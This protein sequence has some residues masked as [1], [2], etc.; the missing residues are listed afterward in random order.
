MAVDVAI[1][2]KILQTWKTHEVPEVWKSSPASIQKFMPGWEHVFMTNDDN[3]AF[4]EQHFPDFLPY[5]DGF[6]Y[7]IMRADAIRYMWL[8]VSGGLYVDLDI[9]IMKPLD[10]LF[11]HGELFV[12]P[13][14]NTAW[15]LTNSFMASVP[16]HPVWLDVIDEMKKPPSP[17]WITK[18]MQIIG[19][20]GPAML[21]RVVKRSKHPYTVL[22]RLELMRCTQCDPTPCFFEGTYIRHLE[23]MSWCSWDS[24][25]FNLLWCNR[26]FFAMLLIVLVVVLLA[27]FGHKFWRYGKFSCRWSRLRKK[28]FPS[29]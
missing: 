3:R 19:Q 7:P 5:Y 6:K 9:E 18:H 25:L 22:P 28:H 15:V 21:D 20:T 13:S 23:G 17:L 27:Y 26:Q 11:T 16:G 24:R 4:V 1:P 29:F 2:R 12:V 8:Y 10:D 14:G